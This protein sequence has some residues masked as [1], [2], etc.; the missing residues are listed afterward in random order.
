MCLRVIVNC[1][2]CLKQTWTEKLVSYVIVNVLHKASKDY[3]NVLMQYSIVLINLTAC[4][5]TDFWFANQI[6]N[7]IRYLY[8]PFAEDSLD[9]SRLL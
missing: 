2:I 8:L 5:E 9:C 3:Y 7:N 1:A 4:R 6:Q